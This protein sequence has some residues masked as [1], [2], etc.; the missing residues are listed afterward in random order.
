MKKR[1]ETDTNFLSLYRYYCGNTEVPELFHLWSGISLVA[2]CMGN[3]VWIEKFKGDR[4]YPNLYILLIGPS[5]SGKGI[6]INKAVKFADLETSIMNPFRMSGTKRG[7]IQ[8][9]VRPRRFPDPFYHGSRIY[10]ISPELVNDIGSGPLADEWVR[11]MTAMFTETDTKCTDTT[12]IHGIQVLENPLINWLGGSTEEWMRKSISEDAITGGFFA[13]TVVVPGEVNYEHR[14]H[15]PTVPWDFEEVRNHLSRRISYF[16]RI[17]GQMVLSPDAEQIDAQWYNNRPAPTEE[18]LSAIWNREHDIILKVAMVIAMCDLLLWDE[19]YDFIIKRHH[20]QVAQ[21]LV[22]DVRA[23]VGAII[24]LTTD[25]RESAMFETVVK[26]IKDA[27]NGVAH[28]ALL[29]KVYPKGIGSK[30]L[31]NL[32]A[33]LMEAGHVEIEFRGERRA[34]YYVWKRKRLG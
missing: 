31:A 22:A 24:K 10:M 29:K 23:N 7:S 11:W 30:L 12:G 8:L 33:T 20:I 14:V 18:S 19:R 2:S 15:K 26:Y 3:N 6:A 21:K 1:Y 32:V 25:T 34:K 28:T 5:A 27:K 13:R 9:L 4:L 16:C 17:Y